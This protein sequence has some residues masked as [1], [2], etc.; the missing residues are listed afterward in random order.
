MNEILGDNQ[1]LADVELSDSRSQAESVAD[2]SASPVSITGVA[3]SREISMLVPSRES[4]A[5]ESQEGSHDSRLRGRSSH[6]RTENSSHDLQSS[7]QEQPLY[8]SGIQEDVSDDGQHSSPSIEAED[9]SSWEADS[10]YDWINEW[11]DPELLLEWGD[12]DIYSQRR[13]DDW[14]QLLGT[15]RGSA[16]DLRLRKGLWK[17]LRLEGIDYMECGGRHNEKVYCKPCH[18]PMKFDKKCKAILV[19]SESSPDGDWN[20]VECRRCYSR[21][22]KWEEKARKEAARKTTKNTKS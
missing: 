5:G 12:M 6:F 20:T 11:A 1:S 9:S 17:V 13:L 10:R 19:M 16:S 4:S 7:H 14:Y 2:T 18:G 8:S 22:T 21:K 15:Q 3:Q